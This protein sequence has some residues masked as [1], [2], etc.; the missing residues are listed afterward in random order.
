MMPKKIVWP[1]ALIF[2][3]GT[4]L[5]SLTAT[6]AESEK[7][8]NAEYSVSSSTRLSLESGVG[9]I[10]FVR[11]DGDTL[12]VELVATADDDDSW[13]DGDVERVE[14]E[15]RQDGDRLELS[16]PEQDNVQITWTVTLPR[17][18]EVDVEL[19]VGSM[20]GEMWTTDA[21]FEVGVGELDLTLFGDNFRRI[22]A[23][24]GIGDAT[25]KGVNGVTE[26]TFIAAEATAR[27]D[28]DADISAEV[29]VG[30]V[31]IRVDTR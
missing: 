27:G 5:A 24:V 29:G 20:H 6:A 7:V 18:A 26:R 2:I 22:D 13:N 8:I 25:I 30:E 23:E 15:A 3:G 12:T 1:V 14:L 31:T 11:G 21:H 17:V 28:G 16:V 4:T 19:G 9:E 10:E